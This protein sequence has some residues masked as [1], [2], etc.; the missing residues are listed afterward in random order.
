MKLLIAIL[1]TGFCEAQ[2]PVERPFFSNSAVFVYGGKVSCSPD[3]Q[4]TVQVIQLKDDNFTSA[5]KIIVSGREVH[6]PIKFGLNA[7]VLWSPDSSAFALTGSD[8]GASG[9]CW[10]DVFV[11]NDKRT[12]QIPIT[13]IVQRAFRHPA[14]CEV[15]ESPNV[16]AVDWLKP[17][18]RLLVGV[19]VINHSVCAD[20]GRFRAYE[21]DLKTKRILHSY[22]EPEAKQ[23]FGKSLGEWLLK[24]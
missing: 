11:L 6:E 10:T 4:N 19:Q 13:P 18:V 5:V 14:K 24:P 23:L 7:Q 8:T 15:P 22:G 20:A 17:S 12:H 3:G 16:V 1:L 9:Q 2:S 21:I